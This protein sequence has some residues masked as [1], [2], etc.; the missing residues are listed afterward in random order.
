MRAISATLVGRKAGSPSR[1]ELAANPPSVWREKLKPTAVR[2]T[3]D[4]GEP[5]LRLRRDLTV[6]CGLTALVIGLSLLGSLCVA[7]MS[8][9]IELA[10]QQ[11]CEFQVG[12]RTISAG[13]LTLKDTNEAA[14]DITRAQEFARTLK[15]D[16]SWPD[17]DYASNA[18]SGWPCSIHYTRMLSMVAAAHRPGASATDRSGFDSAVHRTFAFW[19]AHDFTCPNWWYNQI[20]AP[21]LFGTIALLL[22]D[23]LNPDERRYLTETM[24][25]RSKIDM[26]GQNRIWLAGNTLTLGLLKGDESLV[27]EAAA[28]IWH[29]SAVAGDEGIQPDFSFHQHG[30]QQQFGNYGLGFAVE[31]CR[32]ATILRGTPWALGR[33][34]LAAYRG[35]LLDG[36]AWVNWRGRMDISSCGRQFMPRSPA[37]KARTIAQVMRNVA[38]FDQ[39]KAAQYLAAG[40]EGGDEPND[41][42]GNRVFWRSDYVVHR[43]SDWAATLKMSSRRVVGAESLNSENFLGYHLADGALYL[44]ARGDEYD[45]IFPVWDWQ[46]L[47]GVTCAQRPNGPPAFRE[48]RGAADFVGGVTNGSAGCAA[49]DFSRDGV[50]AHKAWFFSPNAVVCLGAGICSTSA[51]RVVTTINQCLLRG[52][53]VVKRRNE[54]PAKFPGGEETIR[55]VEWVEHDGWRYTFFSTATVHLRAMPQRGNWKRVFDNPETPRNEVT[56]PVF[57]LWLEHGTK[58]AN[59]TYAYCIMR[60]EALLALPKIENST[61]AQVVRFGRGAVGFVFWAPGEIKAAESMNVRADQPCILMLDETTG[62]GFVADPTQKLP[63]LALTVGRTLTDV[64]LPRGGGA[65]SA[66]DAVLIRVD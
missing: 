46:K 54:A 55:G 57:T 52:D 41:L 6:R 23:E 48:I 15:P 61:T 7:A 16:G 21:K 14:P 22:G 25:P 29:E 30:P 50:T 20:G 1:H 33:A 27:S 37:V 44:Y 3:T 36:E 49:L 10:R 2:K 18:R 35:F 58:V 34:N 13:N 8:P 19:I 31:I 45:E 60:S 63:R 39:E 38:L 47:P 59:Q 28:T 66:A 32:W 40:R 51:E 62:R 56:L 24:M 26:T 42:I 65:G 4:A 64:V 43:T 12:S 11:F 17:I 53:V 9:A 5:L